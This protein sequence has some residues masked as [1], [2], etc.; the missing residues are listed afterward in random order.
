MSSHSS[1]TI[2]LHKW[3]EQIQETV[4][5]KPNTSYP[6]FGTSNHS[7]TKENNKN[8]IS[9]SLVI[10]FL[11]YKHFPTLSLAA[12]KQE[13]NYICDL[14]TSSVL[15]ANIAA[16]GLLRGT[17]AWWWCEREALAP[18]TDEEAADDDTA[19]RSHWG[20]IVRVVGGLMFM[21]N[22]GESFNALSS[23]T[24][25]CKRLFSSVRFSQQRFKY[26]QSTSV[27]FNLV[28]NHSNPQ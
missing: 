16:H 14:C 27:C 17:G 12:P 20:H 22:C 2:F 9:D 8:M 5:L 3:N 13:W 26:S 10:I 4:P 28:L 15:D 6:T 7:P 18:V 19:T 11:L 25:F 23:L 24:S 21:Y 1:K